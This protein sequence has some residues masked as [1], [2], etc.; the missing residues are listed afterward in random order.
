MATEWDVSTATY[1]DKSVSVT[2]QD[3]YPHGVTFS[4]DGT[5]MYIMGNNTDTVYQYT[6]STAW[7]V[8]TAT[9][10]D[11]SV[12]VTLQ[13]TYP[14]GVTFSSN[15]S[16]MYVVGT[17][18]DTVYQYTLS[19]AWDVSTA[20]YANKS[21]SV[22]AQDTSPTGVTFSSDGTKMYVVGVA[23]DTVYQYTLPP[24]VVTNALF[25]GSNF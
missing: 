7:D 14:T 20:T 24:S 18:T 15:G 13:D 17:D 19:T 8:S 10:A 23:T 12:S 6:L 11:K 9:Y 21:V 25:F 16:K 4:S 22:S 3:I 5:K 2:S 1:A